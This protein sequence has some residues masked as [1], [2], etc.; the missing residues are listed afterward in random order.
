MN[1]NIIRLI[2]EK[3]DIRV[4][5]KIVFC[6]KFVYQI[7]QDL[8][9]N[10]TSIVSKK[11][12]IV[13]TYSVPNNGL[14]KS[15]ELNYIDLVEFYIENGANDIE[16]VLYNASYSGNIKMVDYFLKSRDDYY[17]VDRVLYYANLGKK[18]E[19]SIHLIKVYGASNSISKNIVDRGEY[20]DIIDWSKNIRDRY[21]GGRLKNVF[22]RHR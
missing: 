16:N 11:F 19:L 12:K 5:F 6:N 20:Q 3:C 17:D 10:K 13:K 9:D 22:K 21:F 8:M 1:H 18:K 14:F 7:L 4:L 2:I 15:V